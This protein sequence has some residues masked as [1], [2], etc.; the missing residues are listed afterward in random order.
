M[1]T[2][3]PVAPA[4]PVVPV[5]CPPFQPLPIVPA[6]QSPAW[7]RVDRRRT[8]VTYVRALFAVVGGA[9][10][11][12]TAYDREGILYTSETP[13]AGDVLAR[14]RVWWDAEGSKEEKQ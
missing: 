3:A 5:E 9:L 8:R 10:T 4:W 6:G 7:Y 12:T 14:W 11:S 2:T 1:R 13:L